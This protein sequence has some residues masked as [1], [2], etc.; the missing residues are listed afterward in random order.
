MQHL[1]TIPVLFPERLCRNF[2]SYIYWICQK[3]LPQKKPFCRKESETSNTN[4]SEFYGC[5]LISKLSSLR[6]IFIVPSTQLFKNTEQVAY[7][8]WVYIRL[9]IFS[10]TDVTM[11]LLWYFCLLHSSCF[12]KLW[13]QTFGTALNNAQSMHPLTSDIHGTAGM[14]SRQFCRGRGRGRGREVEAE[15]RQGSNVLYWG[16]ARQRQRQRARGRGRGE[17]VR[18]RCCLCHFDIMHNA[19]VVVTCSCFVVNDIYQWKTLQISFITNTIHTVI[20]L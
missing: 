8:S 17:A 3:I 6:G 12:W 7:I 18:N 11:I 9:F 1:N 2:C 13:R 19:H 10:D 16:E 15:A 14:G 5:F 20:V 4:T